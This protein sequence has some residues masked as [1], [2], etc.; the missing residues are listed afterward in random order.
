MR[1]A[2]RAIAVLAIVALV[3]AVVVAGQYVL[4]F[5]WTM[6]TEGQVRSGTLHALPPVAQPGDDPAP[7]QDAKTVLVARFSPAARGSVVL[8]ERQT[9]RGWRLVGSAQQNTAGQAT[10]TVTTPALDTPGRQYRAT[11]LGPTGDVT[12][13]TSTTRADPWALTF[14]DE[15]DISSLDRTK[16]DY[17][18]L[19]SYNENGSRRCS[20]SDELAVS[21]ARSTLRLNVLVDPARRYEACETDRG[22]LNYYLNGHI[23]TQ[24]RFEFTHGVAA[25]RIKFPR[26]RGQ[27]GA[28]WLQ[29]EGVE[30]TGGDPRSSGAE[31]DVV[32]YFGEGFPKGGLASFIYFLNEREEY[33]KVGGVWPEATEELPPGDAW[34]RSY[35]VF[36]VEWTPRRY[37]FRVDGREIFRARKG[38]SGVNQYLVLSMLSSDWELPH[39]DD[40]RLPSAMHVDWARVWQRPA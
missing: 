35:H 30:Q 19:G 27:H 31:I 8:L 23:S 40:K 12:A 25:A 4:G 36:S 5:R 26:D 6:A 34:W 28:F 18:Q 39:I 21:V 16:W 29:R 32:E 15:F 22:P 1:L 3:G 24:G 17:R 20:K 9:P 14:E 38:I 10:F 11:A 33:E 7:A 37:V 2:A 13:T